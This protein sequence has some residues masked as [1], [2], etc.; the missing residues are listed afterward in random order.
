M[1]HEISQKLGAEYARK[2]SLWTEGLYDVLTRWEFTG[3]ASVPVPDVR[4]PIDA[5]L[6]YGK[7]EF[8]G[9]EFAGSTGVFGYKNKWGRIGGVQWIARS[10]VP[11]HNV[12][13][14]GMGFWNAFSQNQTPG[15]SLCDYI[16]DLD[17]IT[18]CRE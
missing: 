3:R 8:Y 10:S 5:W 4:D 7:H 11:D 1:A 12:N 14:A 18:E 2:F 9:A 6:Q 16:N 17:N 15:F 13:M